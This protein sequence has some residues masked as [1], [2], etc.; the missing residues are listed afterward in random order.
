MTLYQ[1]I[2]SD[3]QLVVFV[4]DMLQAFPHTYQC[5]DTMQDW[6]RE[7]VDTLF[8]RR[9]MFPQT[10]GMAALVNELLQQAYAVVAWEHVARAFRPMY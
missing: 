1:F 8:E 9:D 10:M 2:L 5:A 4:Q 7:Q 6:F 3:G